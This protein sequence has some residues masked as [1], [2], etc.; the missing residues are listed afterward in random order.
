MSTGQVPGGG[1]E[2]E[3][4]LIDERERRAHEKNRFQLMAKEAQRKADLNRQTE[5]LYSR[6]L[7]WQ[8][9]VG[10]DPAVLVEAKEREAE[11]RTAQ[12]HRRA[13]YQRND[14]AEFLREAKAQREGS[15]TA[16]K[17]SIAYIISELMSIC[18]DKHVNPTT[19][20]YDVDWFP[21]ID[22]MHAIR[23]RSDKTK[24]EVGGTWQFF[25]KKSREDIT[26][27][28]HKDKL[29]N[30]LTMAV[31]VWGL[32]R[33]LLILGEKHV[34]ADFHALVAAVRRRNEA[35][36]KTHFG[37]DGKT[38]VPREN[39][40]RDDLDANAT[41][42]AA[43]LDIITTGLQKVCAKDVRQTTD[44][45]GLV[46]YSL[47][48]FMKRVC[49]DAD[50]VQHI[51]EGLRETKKHKS[52][53]KELAPLMPFEYNFKSSEPQY[54][55]SK[56]ATP[57][58]TLFGLQRMLAIIDEKYMQQEFHELA[59]CAKA[60][61]IRMDARE[62]AVSTAPQKRAA[63]L[64]QDAA[65]VDKVCAETLVEKTAGNVWRAQ[66]VQKVGAF[67]TPKK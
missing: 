6:G 11:R 3:R 45:L 53:I 26:T 38:D 46:R 4:A 55:S 32:Q 28:V 22:S 9:S 5:E 44:A 59:V 24:L 65:K 29:K 15:A 58:V 50:K 54:H 37:F 39:A 7:G 42:L 48:D 64:V 10:T 14:E 49:I 52:E 66:K 57:A 16:E 33:T 19:D 20:A 40:L 62:L 60:C 17:S 30:K 21:L 31:N 67:G 23:A 41:R 51:L 47:Y 43:G 12:V 61:F 34:H 2:A 8:A 56:I 27:F 35:L 13:E 1:V 63:G 36:E 18:R 25:T